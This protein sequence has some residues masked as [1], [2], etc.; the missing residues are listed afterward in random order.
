MMDQGQ[1]DSGKRRFGLPILR[2]SKQIDIGE[3]ISKVLQTVRWE[4]RDGPF[5]GFRS[6]PGRF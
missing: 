3:Q 1:K 4:L 2:S 5:E 6:P